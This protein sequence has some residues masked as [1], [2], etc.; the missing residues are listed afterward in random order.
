MPGAL[1]VS[2]SFL[3]GKGGIESYL[4]ELCEELAPH[5][6]VLAPAQRDGVSLPHD[7]AYETIGHPGTMLVP[8]PRVARAIRSAARACRLERVLFGT[9]WPLA[10]LGP[11]LARAGLKYS[12]IVHGAEL[13]V[14]SVVPVVRRRLARAL[15][16]AELLLAVSE[17]T[18]TNIMRFLGKMGFP[19]PPV[20]ILRARVD[21][22]LF[23]PERR[24]PEV[25]TALGLRS[26][27]PMLLCFGRLVPRK[28]VDKLIGATDQI[29]ARVPDVAVVV[30]GTGP[31]QKRLERL[32]AKTSTP[33]LFAG[34]V[35]EEDAPAL[36]ASADAFVLPVADRWFG[37]DVEGLGVVLLEAAASGV[38][39]VAGR[40]GGTPEA[41]VDGV[42]GYLVNAN[43]PAELVDRIVSLLQDE[44]RARGM[45]SAG[46]AFVAE[47]YSNR[48]LPEALVHWLGIAPVPK[49]GEENDRRG[50]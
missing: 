15:G 27:Q 11:S 14:P 16:E 7:L 23:T 6:P 38:P 50:G 31:E 21:L 20:E 43:R 42:T 37:L 22:D 24:D 26:E 49:S 44:E 8:G 41:V 9:P 48:P 3:P 17:Y 25:K 30:A 10:L 46:T 5:L 36:Y 47:R 18:R 39:C 4:A 29:A 1:L 2:S 45:G 19:I 28:G 34:R 35:P 13:L 40:S 33:I 12:V 32:A